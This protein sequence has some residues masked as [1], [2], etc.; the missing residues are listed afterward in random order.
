MTSQSAR[1]IM[2]HCFCGL[3]SYLWWVKVA[4]DKSDFQNAWK[5]SFVVAKDGK[6]DDVVEGSQPSV[7]YFCV[8]GAA[9]YIPVGDS[10]RVRA[11]DQLLTLTGQLKCCRASCLLQLPSLQGPVL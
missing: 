7:R 3:N 9:L 10:P 2:L 11:F 6:V 1:Q 8:L 4:L 5:Q